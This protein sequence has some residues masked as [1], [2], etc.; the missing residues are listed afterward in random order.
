VDLSNNEIVDVPAEIASLSNLT[1]FKIR[2]NKIETISDALFSAC[3]ALVHVDFSSNA[4]PVL[5]NAIGQLSFL[6]EL[7]LGGNR[8][9]ALPDALCDCTRLTM[10]DASDNQL[11]YLPETIGKLR[12]LLTFKVSNNRLTS[13][14]E[15]ISQLTSLMDLSMKNNK[16]VVLPSLVGMTSLVVFDVT[17]NKLIE[18]GIAISPTQCSEDDVYVYSYA[19][20]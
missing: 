9:R 18:V 8:I 15:S 2:N 3:T 17:D 10:L 12:H 1:T 11:E 16:L 13:I 4:I 20:L 14:P 6:S 7:F 5:G 19:Y